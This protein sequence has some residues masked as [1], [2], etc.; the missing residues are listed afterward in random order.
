M[1]SISSAEAF[2]A[3][4]DVRHRL[5]PAQPR[6]PSYRE[7]ETLDDIAD[8]FDIFLLDAFGV[9]NVG[10]TAIPGVRE[11]IDSLRSAGKRVL[12]LSNAASVPH[13][14]LRDKYSR[15]G[16][17]FAT[18]DIITS[19]ATMAACMEDVQG[20]EW[21]VMLGS[22]AQLEDFAPLSMK[23]LAD[24]ADDYRHVGGFLL[25]GSG[26]WTEKRQELLEVALRQRPRRVLVANPDIVA[27]RET[28]FSAE[29][30]HFAHRLADHT[31]VSPEFFGKPF[32]NIFDLA[33]KRV[34][35]VERSR[36]LMVGDS[37][38]TDVL[39]AQSA[40]VAS[41]LVTGYGFFAGQDFRAAIEAAQI[42]PDYVVSRP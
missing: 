13:S 23:A 30:G 39:G 15:M 16:F 41:A 17:D 18:E 11:R 31:G 8:D 38:H 24:D 40:G 21:G 5:P 22:N 20:V 19:R 9:L 36:V 42:I 29:P 26:N 32:Q 33:F 2:N 12:V 14:D 27:P 34:G 35:P 25:I 6:V 7:I 4:E 28:G 3:Y 37:L 10:E 1:I